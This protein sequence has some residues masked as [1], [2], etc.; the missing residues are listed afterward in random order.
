MYDHKLDYIMSDCQT[1]AATNPYQNCCKVFLFLRLSNLTVDV[2][3]RLK[4]IR[5]RDR[6]SE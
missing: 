1:L 4:Q 3:P 2:A 6:G 5:D